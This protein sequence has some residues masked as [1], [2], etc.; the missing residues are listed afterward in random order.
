MRWYRMMC[1]P[2]LASLTYLVACTTYIPP[3]SSPA[4]ASSR[5]LGASFDRV[6]YALTERA[7]S[8]GLR[9]QQSDKANG[10]LIL[11]F[12]PHSTT[13][14]V[15]CGGADG[16]SVTDPTPALPALGVPVTSLTVIE[17]VTVKPEGADRTVV[18]LD[19]HYKLDGYHVGLRGD[20][21]RIGE[22]LFNSASS[23]TQ[24]VGMTPVECRSTNAVE[25]AILDDIAGQVHIAL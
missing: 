23:A 24:K 18:E 5:A 9:V 1:L 3:A 12:E 17:D 10:R 16:G 19:G 4:I 21:T 13:P 11:A 7:G 20:Q 25:S 6:W 14:Y 22:W 15:D 8:N 2:L